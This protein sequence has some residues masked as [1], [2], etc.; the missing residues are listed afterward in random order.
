[1][2]SR[3]EMFSPQGWNRWAAWGGAFRAG[4]QNTR[5]YIDARADTLDFV[6]HYELLYQGSRYDLSASGYEHLEPLYRDEHPQIAL[7]AGAQTGKT[8]WMMGRV[9]RNAVRKPAGQ[10]G[11]YYPTMDLAQDVSK[12]RFAP[13]MLSSSVLKR[14]LKSINPATKTQRVVD[15][16]QA[17]QVGQHMVR[18]LWFGR[19]T[20]ESYTLDYLYFDEVRRMSES[21]LQLAYE[22]QSAMLEYGR[23]WISTAGMP[24][25][26][27][28]K[29]FQSSDQRYYHSACA[30]PEGCVLSLTYPD[31]MADLR[32]ASP[33]L[34]RKVQHAY[35]HAGRPYLG[36]TGTSAQEF[37]G[38]HAAFICPKC[39]E[40]LVNPREGWWEEHEP[41]RFIHGYQ[42]PQMLSPSYPPPRVLQK[43]EQS[44]DL[45]EIYRSMVGRPFVDASEIPVT[46]ADLHAAIRPG[47]TWTCP[48]G[49]E[50][51]GVRDRTVARV[52]GVDVQRGYFVGVI[53]RC[54][55]GG[56]MQVEHLFVM[57]AGHPLAQEF[58][59]IEKGLAVLLARWGVR[60]A[61]IDAGPEWQAARAIQDALPGIVYLGM[62][63]GHLGAR[64]SERMLRWS[65]DP[66]RDA[67]A[68]LAP[69]NEAEVVQ[70]NRTRALRWSAERWRR[71]ENLVPN[72]AGLILELPVQVKDGT[73]EVLFSAE[74]RQ[75]TWQAVRLAETYLLHQKSVAFPRRFRNEQAER[76]GA[77]TITA[78]NVGRDP[79]F[80]HAEMFAV[81]AATRV[82][83]KLRRVASGG[84]E[85]G[86]DKDV[87][88]EEDEAWLG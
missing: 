5:T 67:G 35:A 66:D 17:R 26:T 37:A 16:V 69:G 48:R 86:T 25:T 14:A 8:A 46:D 57:H 13:M 73:Q 51:D 24:K 85:A 72:P 76:V 42:L 56:V 21:W 12:N 47:L 36:L 49:D 77:Y 75:G 55:G 3:S 28:D 83:S 38:F 84:S 41:G 19:T 50:G 22:R 80:A 44:P 87:A 71:R 58:G 68:Q 61:V 29:I 62:E 54:M 34:V 9:G 31:C 40:V 78:E 4:I 88:A 39:G 74:L 43:M 81:V 63:V 1:M 64:G 6:T 45:G 53:K 20:T 2:P 79:H 11:V 70:I 59:D 10:S 30:C 82:D 65:D 23:T 7:M 60:V 52:A 18:F 15:G 33:E 32:H 27:I